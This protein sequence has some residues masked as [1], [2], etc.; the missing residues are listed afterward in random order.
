[1]G[2]YLRFMGE[3]LIF[4]A[5]YRVSF[6]FKVV[7]SVDLMVLISDY[8]EISDPYILASTEISY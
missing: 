5:H 1:M 3:P 8:R 2:F 7:F 6:S 4:T